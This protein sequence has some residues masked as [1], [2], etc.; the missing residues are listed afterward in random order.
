MRL[1]LPDAPSQAA[2]LLQEWRR[3]GAFLRDT[4][5]SIWWHT[6]TYVA[7]DGDEGERSGFL[8]AIRLAAYDEG[9]IRRARAH[10][11]RPPARAG[12]S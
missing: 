8:S 7:P 3:E 11:R 12:S 9:R 10:A 2:R 1:L 4:Q 5:P 6:Q